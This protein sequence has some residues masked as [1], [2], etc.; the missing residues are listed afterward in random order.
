MVHDDNK[1]NIP[2][3]L[4]NTLSMWISS[5]DRSRSFAGQLL[6]KTQDFEGYEQLMEEIDELEEVLKDF[7][8]D[9]NAEYGDA[10]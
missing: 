3:T 7:R 6:A 9:M 8:K 4:N 5:L 1:I 2:H 10:E